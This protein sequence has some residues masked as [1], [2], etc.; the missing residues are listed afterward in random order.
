M[1]IIWPDCSVLLELH[2]AV[3]IKMIEISIGYLLNI[4]FVLVIHFHEI[5]LV[6]MN[7]PSKSLVTIKLELGIYLYST[8][9]TVMNA[10]NQRIIVFPKIPT[11]Y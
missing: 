5:L 11:F 2:K 9:S 1:L 8:V 3:V 10:G 4:G 6:Q 7:R